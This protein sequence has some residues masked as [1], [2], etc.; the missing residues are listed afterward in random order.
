MPNRGKGERTR[1]ITKGETTEIKK[2]ILLL[3]E[4]N[5]IHKGGGFKSAHQTS[6]S[7]KR[8]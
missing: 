8:D 7:V 4:E 5:K 1:G 3:R 6:E 2:V